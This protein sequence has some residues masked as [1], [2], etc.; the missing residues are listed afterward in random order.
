MSDSYNE[1]IRCEA[2]GAWLL[3]TL[4]HRPVAGTK[5]QLVNIE[6][7]NDECYCEINGS[8]LHHFLY[9]V[10][11]GSLSFVSLSFK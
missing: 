8:W 9:V 2:T 4:T 5:R 11:T 1:T 7:T 10:W 6:Q 3:V